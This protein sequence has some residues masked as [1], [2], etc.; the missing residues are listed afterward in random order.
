MARKRNRKRA[1]E[2]I[3]RLF[4][5]AKLAAIADEIDRANRYVELA[6]RIGMR[7]N[8]PLPSRYRR[9]VCKRCYRYLYPSKTCR[10]RVREGKVI[11]KC[12]ECGFI[13]RF[14]YS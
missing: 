8:V 5:E 10:V 12:L 14:G 6:R 4:Q 1:K 3:E 2:R 7:Y 9:R 11:T 13:N